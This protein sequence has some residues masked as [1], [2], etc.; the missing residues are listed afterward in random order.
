MLTLTEFAKRISEI[1]PFIMREFSR[2]QANE[3]YK[4]KI[5][6]PQFFILDYLYTQDGS[7]MTDLAKFMHVTTAAMT[8]IVERLVKCGYVV[9]IPEPDD[10]RI[11]KVKITPRGLELVKRICHQRRQMTINIFG[12]LSEDDRKEYLRLLTR[13]RDILLE[14]K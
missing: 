5:T 9:R 3:L 13:L 14:A 2:R 12:K 10:R 7:R 8:G 11:I 6:V 4:G 1:M